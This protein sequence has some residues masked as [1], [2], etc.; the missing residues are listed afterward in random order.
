VPG[1][2]LSRVAGLNQALQ[3]G[4]GI[5]A[6]P[7]GALL[8]ETLPMQ[9]VIAVDLVTALLAITILLFVRVP[10]PA[11]ARAVAGQAGAPS[12]T[13][14]LR[15]GLR[16]VLAWP[17]LLII[18]G[19][20]LVINFLLTPGA[21]LLP[22]LVAEHFRGGALQLA[23]LN[24]VFGGGVIAGGVLLG[25]WG[26][27]R[28]RVYTSL[29]GLMGLG[30]SFIL[31]GFTPASAFWLALVAAGI[32]A[33]MQALTNGPMMAIL[34]AAVAPEMQGRVFSLVMAGSAGMAPLGLL[35][36]G[37]VADRFGVQSWFLVGGLA[38]ALMGVLGFF[39][40]A[41]V[42]LEAQ[43]AAHRA[44]APPAAPEPAAAP[45]PT[46]EPVA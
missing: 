36:G 14:E 15:A 17:G 25:V 11:R 26:G 3:G 5:V 31:L 33:V 23:T 20:A 1:Q 37:P 19:M 22:L 10:Q 41:V 44:V 46:A 7:L 27:F 29:L 30:L 42:N 40:P 21:S 32:G 39:L 6:P 9:G 28:R 4:M 16:Y 13:A 18:L 34:Q 38:C 8:L 24:A 2:H 12:F 35:I 45:P 43:A